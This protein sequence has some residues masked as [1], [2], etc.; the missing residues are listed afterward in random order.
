MVRNLLHVYRSR[1]TAIYMSGGPM[2]KKEANYVAKK[3]AMIKKNVEKLITEWQNIVLTS[4]QYRYGF[5]SRKPL[6]MQLGNWRDP[7]CH[8]TS[9]TW[10][11]EKI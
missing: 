5:E 1:F 9:T 8:H 7:K 10:C 4:E 2:I 11:S 6:I 3:E